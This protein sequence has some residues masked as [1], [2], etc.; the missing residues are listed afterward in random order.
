MTRTVH[1][2]AGAGQMSEMDQ[3]DVVRRLYAAVAD[4]DLGAA[5]T[6]FASPRFMAPPRSVTH[7]GRPCRLG[8]DPG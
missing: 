1:V 5:E 7:R 8:G 2:W 4:R 3:V 6:C